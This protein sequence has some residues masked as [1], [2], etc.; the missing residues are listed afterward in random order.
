MRGR[1]FTV[2]RLVAGLVLTMIL[3][4]A[5]APVRAQDDGPRVYQLAPIGAQ[6]I[7]GF[8]VVKR[9]NEGPEPGDVHPGSEIDTDIVV[10]RYAGT[11]DVAG[12]PLT[13]FA[14]LPVGEVR[15]TGAPAS[16]GFGDAQVGATLGLVG[17]PALNAKA[18]AA[19]RPGFGLAVLGR[20]FLPTGAYSSGQPVN[21]GS[22]RV[23][24]QLGLP[25]SLA[26]GRPYREP[27]FTSL[28]V[29]PTLTF[30]EDNPDPFGADRSSKDALFSLEAH[31]IRNF[32][33]R[34]WASADLLFRHGGA[35]QIDGV[36]SGDHTRGWSAGASL[37]V[38]LADRASAIFTYQR[39]VE[40]D[41]DGPDGWF[42]RTALVV[43]F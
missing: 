2:L 17:S 12:R 21:F 25:L 32:T 18:F 5:A 40:R 8:A 39:V 37:A 35:T 23:S 14:I 36:A 27:G 42:F 28:E 34:V 1:A 3:T 26:N 4:L 29:L 38:P 9:G 13:P 7:T 41:D 22:N 6:T 20:V 16:S 15:A 33:P 11:F 10:L 19:Y 31:L 30:Y 43:P 24:Y